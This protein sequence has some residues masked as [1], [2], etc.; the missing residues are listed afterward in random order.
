MR[1]ILALALLAVAALAT[2]AF[3]G[4][5]ARLSG[6]ITDAVTKA[7]IPDATVLIV[8]VKGAPHTFRQEM[9]ASKDGSYAIFILDA[10]MKYDFTYTAPGHAAFV[11]EAVKLD[12][13]KPN[14]RD[15]EL[16]PEG[17]AT[18]AAA[19]KAAPAEAKIDPAVVAFNQGAALANEGK[20]P[21][22]IAKMEEAVAARPSLTAGYQ[23]LGRLY[24]RQKDYA[25]AIDNASK[26]LALD[27][28]DVDMNSVMFDSYTATGDASK[29]AQYKAKL[30]ANAGLLFNDAAKLINSGKDAEAEPLLKQSIAAD[31]KFAPSYYELGM[32]Y[33]RMQKNADAK[34]NLEKYLELAPTGKEAPTAKEMLKYVK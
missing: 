14:V 5:E 1:R 3:A 33:V 15:V 18:A 17:A 22:A 24:L 19:G 16:K 8:A 30:P 26:V 7:P 6:K 34:A 23:A 31:E 2:N 32:L 25:K 27:P 29:A 21:E 12:L 13:G 28:D 20:L 4:V 10:T 9:K 11:D